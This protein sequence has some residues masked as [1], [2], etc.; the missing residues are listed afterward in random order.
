MALVT[1]ASSG[2]G[3]DIAAELARRGYGLVIVSRTADKL[4]AA[5]E[6]LS[7]EGAP[8]VIVKPLDLAATGAAETLYDWCREQ[9][10]EVEVL[11][12][13]AGIF[14]FKDFLE[15]A[16]ERVEQILNLHIHTVTTLC[17]LF[18]AE[19]AA[20]GYGYILN[21]SSYSIWMPLPGLALYS[22]TKSYVHEFTVAFAKEVREKG[23]YVTAVSP[24]GVA[25]DMYGLSQRLQHIALYWGLLLSPAQ[26]ARRSVGALFRGRRDVV[27]G[28]ANRLLIPVVKNLPPCVTRFLR[29]KTMRFQK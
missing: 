6:L 8:E 7:G 9:G 29:R 4:S 5:A 15:T 27:P 25:T 26:V 12:N 24:A 11:V 21:L 22:A 23:V 14:I 28:W 3:L 2:I 13:D 17:R 1:G 10:I 20:K 19:M 18:G 16:P